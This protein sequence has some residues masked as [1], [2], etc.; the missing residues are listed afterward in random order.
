K[1]FFS[2][3]GVILAIGA[4]AF[5]TQQLNLGIDFESGTRIKA[6]LDQPLPETDNDRTALQNDVRDALQAA[7]VGGMDSAEIQT[8]SEEGFGDTVVQIAG[9]I[10]PDDVAKVQTTLT[11]DF[12]LVG[13]EDGFDSNSIGPTFGEQIARSALI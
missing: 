13:G 5:A 10:P 12:G 7:N 9:K 1:Y 11:D 3:S 2:F 8:A 4:I 6:A